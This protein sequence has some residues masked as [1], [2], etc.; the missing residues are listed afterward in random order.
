[1]NAERGL[2]VHHVVFETALNHLIVLV[3]LIAET[4]P[5]VLAHTVQRENSGAGNM[6]LAPPQNHPAL[7]GRDVLGHVEAE[8]AEVAKR[9]C[10]AP[11][12][13]GLDS[14]RAILDDGQGHGDPRWP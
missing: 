3:A 14:V 5:G 12:V 11:A 2:Q 6:F 13:L 7:A 1:M 4:M 8:A 10:L 9:P